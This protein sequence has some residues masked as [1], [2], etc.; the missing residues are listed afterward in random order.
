MAAQ[1]LKKNASIHKKMNPYDSRES[2]EANQC[3]CVRQISLFKTLYS[4]ITSFRRDSYMHSTYIQNF[5][6]VVHNDMT[7]YAL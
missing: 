3:V 5:R 4:K 7:Y 6:D 2:S 1:I